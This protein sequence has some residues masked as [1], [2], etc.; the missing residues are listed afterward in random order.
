VG[1]CLPLRNT[2]SMA[3]MALGSA[4]RYQAL[5]DEPV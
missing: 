3:G 2:T 4:S 1:T 5:S